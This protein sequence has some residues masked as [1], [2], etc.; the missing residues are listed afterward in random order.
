MCLF[1]PIIRMSYI[2]V[3]ACIS[4]AFWPSD[5]VRP[6]SL[7]SDGRPPDGCGS[8]LSLVHHPHRPSFRRRAPC[9]RPSLRCR[10]PSN[11][12]PPPPPA[13]AVR[14]LPP[15]T[16]C[17]PPRPPRPLLRRAPEHRLLLP[18]P[19]PTSAGAGVPGRPSSALA[20]ARPPR[21][22][23]LKICYFFLSLATIC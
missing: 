10:T 4:R 8:W 19:P 23:C 9:H 11:G 15:G 1:S 5:G 17:P 18:P 22:R 3:G 21:L 6:I 14:C 7:P 20:Q 2:V 12:H 13:P 16:G